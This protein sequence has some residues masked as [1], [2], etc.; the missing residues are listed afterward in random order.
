MRYK[1]PEDGKVY[2]YITNNF[3]LAAATIA[4]IYK[5]RWDIELFFKWIKQNLRVKTFIGTSEN[6]LRIQIWTAAIV[7]LLL[8]Y[9]RFV[10]KTLFSLT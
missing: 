3:S 7:Y 2:D 8:E 1:N 10:S 6:A 9:I 5:S 4:S